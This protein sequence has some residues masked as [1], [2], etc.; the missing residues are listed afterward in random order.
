[1]P[2]SF[3]LASTNRKGITGLIMEADT[4]QLQDFIHR[5]SHFIITTHASPDA[6][7]LGAELLL[8]EL[9]SSLEKEVWILNSD[10]IP[11]RYLFMDPEGHI[12]AFKEGVPPFPSEKTGVCIVDTSDEYNIGPIQ[13]VLFQ[14]MENFFIID[15]H[16]PSPLTQLPV[17][18]DTDA[19]ATS[20]IITDLVR[21]YNVPISRVGAMAAYAGLVYDTGSFIYPK[22]TSRTFKTALFLV[23]AG[24]VPS[25][26]YQA[27][28]ETASIGALL[29]QKK[30]LSTLEIQGNGHVALQYMTKEDLL[31][32]GAAYED[33]EH[34]INLPLKSRDIEVSIFIKQNLDGVIRC[35]FRSKGAINVASIAQ[36]FGG[37]G[38]KNAAGFKSSD[39]LEETRQKVLQRVL[40]LFKG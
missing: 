38:H 16:E 29:L 33:A 6:D 1:M 13:E 3:C 11:E 40:P 34:F 20:E 27:L 35:S 14:K 2:G 37:G 39:N 23:E 30:V 24:A 22:T 32:T 18:S 17:Y 8:R 12:K 19:A 36:G 7:G 31:E 21:L 15:H 4:Q 26:V 5:F 9:L 28:Y 10:P 25:E